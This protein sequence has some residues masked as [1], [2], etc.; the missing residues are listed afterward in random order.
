MKKNNASI[1]NEVLINDFCKIIGS[2]K[3]NSH[4]SI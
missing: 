3:G 4:E 2:D 1:V